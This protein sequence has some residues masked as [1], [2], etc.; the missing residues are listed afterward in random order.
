MVIEAIFFD[1]DGTLM[2]DDTSWRRCVSA[3][4]DEVARRHR[5]IDPGALSA[6]YYAAAR[7][8]WDEVKGVSA[9]PWGNTDDPGLARRVWSAALRRSP[10]AG[11]DATAHAVECYSRLRSTDTPLYDDVV[12]CLS[13]LRGRYR[14]GVIT[15]GSNATHLPKVEASGL[16]GYFGSVTT[17]DCGSGKPFRPIF[18]QA[19]ASLEAA[20]A[21]ALYVGDWPFA[22]IGG[23]NGA[24]MV[25]VWINR[26][27]A[28]L[29]ADDPVPD[30]QIASLGDLPGVLD[31]LQAQPA[32]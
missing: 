32:S 19:L 8:L 4:I 23:A 27:G 3:T 6:A 20:P 13:G 17:T 30:A 26:A 7:R 29:A 24:G 28:A 2:D 10:A 25:S 21:R 18:A 1:W 22:D 14:L 12:D 11:D 31:R 5:G 15:N 9:P 16:R